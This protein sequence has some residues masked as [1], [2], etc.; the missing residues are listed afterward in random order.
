MSINCI[1]I[2]FI[3]FD[4]TVQHRNKMGSKKMIFM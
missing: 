2:L 4:W 3:T 1:P